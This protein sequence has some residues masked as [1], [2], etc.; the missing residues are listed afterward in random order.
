MDR[1]DDFTY[2]MRNLDDP[3]RLRVM[4][5]GARRIAKREYKFKPNWSLAMEVFGVGST[6]A[7]KICDRAGIDPDGVSAE[8]YKPRA[9]A[10]KE[11]QA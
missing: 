8:F 1:I 2:V 9:L 11:A 4:M 3:I 6:Y 10:A 5:S 7:W